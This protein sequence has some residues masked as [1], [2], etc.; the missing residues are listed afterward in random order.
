MKTLL[1]KLQERIDKT[2]ASEIHG[3][4]T[5]ETREQQMALNQLI[6]MQLLQ[7]LLKEE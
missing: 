6:I 5:R 7:E 2:M 3:A 1:K 4:N